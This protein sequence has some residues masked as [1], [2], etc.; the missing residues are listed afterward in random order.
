EAATIPAPRESANRRNLNCKRRKYVLSCSRAVMP[1]SLPSDTGSRIP[2]R[3][4]LSP[5]PE[6]SHSATNSTDESGAP[7][8]PMRHQLPYFQYCAIKPTFRLVHV[9]NLIL[10]GLDGQPSTSGAH[11]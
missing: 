5:E 6:P 7:P 4:P 10:A 2:T 9:S 8:S 3:P 11:L 1:C